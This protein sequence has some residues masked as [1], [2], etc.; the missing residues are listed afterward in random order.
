MDKQYTLA[1]A[2]AY[3]AE[4][5]AEM[6]KEYDASYFPDLPKAWEV[7]QAG[8]F[9]GHYLSEHGCQDEQRHKILFAAGQ[10]GAPAIRGSGP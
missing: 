8:C 7:W 1:E 5:A 9:L 3:C 2:Q 4:H 6:R 10:R